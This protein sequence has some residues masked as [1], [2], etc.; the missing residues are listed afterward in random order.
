M[1]LKFI[2]LF[3]VIVMMALFFI[4]GKIVNSR[5]Y[6][7]RSIMM[8]QKERELAAKA[9]LNNNVIEANDLLASE[10]GLLEVMR[11][12]NEGEEVK[13]PYLAFDYIYRNINKVSLI[14]KEGKL[15]IVNQNDFKL[16][17]Q[18]AMELLQK[19]DQKEEENEISDDEN[20]LE[21][22]I[23]KD[24]KLFDITQNK[25]GN[26]IKVDSHKNAT[27]VVDT[28]GKIYMN[29]STEKAMVTIDNNKEEN[30]RNNNKVIERDIIKDRMMEKRVERM[31]DQLKL[32][33]ND[34]Y[35][36]ENKNTKKLQLK[37]IKVQ[38]NRRKVTNTTQYIYKV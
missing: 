34:K 3:F 26:I 19:T 30:P 33:K 12:I 2:F 10:N 17:Q 35:G 31:E 32:L 16:F 18:T 4:V 8:V 1:S 24:T 15:V 5:W 20:L 14:D 37:W 22:T 23:T 7:V 11:K 28:D 13:I 6:R 29:S 21:K 36:V 9:S 27:T 25:D 38:K